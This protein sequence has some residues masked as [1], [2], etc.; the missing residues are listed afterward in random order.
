MGCQL[1]GS[2]IDEDGAQLGNTIQP[3]SANV[4]EQ[5]RQ[6][7]NSANVGERHRTDTD[8]PLVRHDADVSVQN[9]P[10]DKRIG[11][12]WAILLELERSATMP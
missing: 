4:G 2:R 1:F 8:V 9:H 6:V 11:W 5:E 7:D 3:D 12:V 10:R